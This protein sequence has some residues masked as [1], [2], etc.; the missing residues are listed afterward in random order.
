VTEPAAEPLRADADASQRW[1]QP[2]KTSRAFEEI[3]GQ[4]E[5]AL[6]SGQLAA[7]GRLPAER[8]FAAALGVSRTSVREALRVLE[9]LGLVD[10]SR[11]RTGA[12]L[13]SE[14]GNAFVDILRLH[15]AFDHYSWESIVEVRAILEAWAFS[16]AARRPDERLLGELSDLLEK[17][18]EPNV[19]PASFLDL[20]VAFHSAVVAASGNQLVAGI[21]TG[22]S[23]LIRKGMFEGITAHAWPDT[24]QLL[25]DDHRELYEA[26]QSA[27]PVRASEVVREHIRRWD[28]R[29][30]GDASVGER[31][32]A[33][34]LTTRA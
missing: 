19:E 11:G 29:R 13:R 30:P 7:G 20:D 9:A 18:S 6:L 24:A 32:S 33:E 23:T 21:L 27:E 8:D 2:I 14:P 16:D 31:A 25:I 5:G 4:L 12:V 34:A 3:L 28:P 17:M 1:I 26:V 10:V 15:V 22:C